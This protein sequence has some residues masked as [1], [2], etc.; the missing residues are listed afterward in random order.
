MVPPRRPAA[1]LGDRRRRAVRHHRPARPAPIVARLRGRQVDD[2]ELAQLFAEADA[3]GTYVDTIMLDDDVN[4]VLAPDQLVHYGN[5]SCDPS[6]WHVDPTTIATRRD[7]R[8][9]E[10]LTIDYATQTIHPEFELDCKCGS[11][12]LP[13][14]GH[15]R[16]LD[17]SGVAPALPRARR[18]GRRAGD[19]PLGGLIRRPA[20][21]SAGSTGSRRSR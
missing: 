17:R 3:A 15:R 14:H 13:R 18:A 9:G 6:M 11:A 19:R 7:V 21:A 2:V 20:S 1:D 4:L 10:E 12:H 8:A 5:H 16:R